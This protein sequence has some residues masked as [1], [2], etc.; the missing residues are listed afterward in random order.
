MFDYGAILLIVRKPLD[1]TLHRHLTYIEIDSRKHTL[2]V[3]TCTGHGEITF[4]SHHK[5]T[6]LKLLMWAIRKSSPICRR[7]KRGGYPY[8]AHL[9]YSMSQMCVIEFVRRG[10]VVD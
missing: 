5:W 10:W 6:N 2:N 9:Y 7:L 4:F 1:F 8:F 3:Q